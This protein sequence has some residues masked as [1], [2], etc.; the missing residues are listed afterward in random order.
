MGEVVRP[1]SCSTIAAYSAQYDQATSE[2]ERQALG[3]LL[4]YLKRTSQMALVHTFVGNALRVER[5]SQKQTIYQQFLRRYPISWIPIEQLQTLPRD[6]KGYLLVT[7]M[8]T[9]EHEIDTF[10]LPP[11]SEQ[12]QRARELAF[13]RTSETFRSALE[14]LKKHLPTLSKWLMG[15]I[16]W[17]HR[18]DTCFNK[19][20]QACLEFFAQHCIAQYRKPD[21][22]QVFPDYIHQAMPD[23]DEEKIKTLLCQALLLERLLR[24]FF[25]TAWP[26]NAQARL[27]NCTLQA[28]D[29]DRA[30]LQNRLDQF[31]PDIETEINTCSHPD[32]CQ[33]ALSMILEAFLNRFDPDEA[34]RLGVIYTPPEVVNFMCE[35]VVS[36]IPTWYEGRTISDRNVP[37]LDP[38]AGTGIFIENMLR[39]IDCRAL[40]YKFR[41]EM[42]CIEI[43]LL[44][45]FVAT[46]NIEETYSQLTGFYEP[47]AGIRYTNTLA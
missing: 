28:L 29:F 32:Q 34:D 9:D 31:I 8:P 23:L 45:Y 27:I 39:R 10:S 22:L 42:F 12:V 33:L 26:S 4:Y 25:P 36:G 5:D 3:K 16:N 30:G 14:T 7:T 35:S 21:P 6:K 11:T 37:I 46:L 38:A 19:A 2:V 1:L 17:A 47:F 13:L 43:M 24:K 40:P 44:P 18:H 41:N 15:Q 20:S